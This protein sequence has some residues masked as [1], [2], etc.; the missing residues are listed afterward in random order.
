MDILLFTIQ[1]YCTAVEATMQ[2]DVK[3]K[4][5]FDCRHSDVCQYFTDNM[6]VNRI[7]NVHFCIFQESW[8]YMIEIEIWGIQD[9]E[10]VQMLLS[11]GNQINMNI[12]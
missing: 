6:N 9:Q 1:R 5:E 7:I 4:K 2:K 12:M 3:V 11:E 8:E 10:I